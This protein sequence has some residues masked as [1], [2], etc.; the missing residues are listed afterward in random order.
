LHLDQIEDDVWTIPAENM[1]A[2][3]GKEVVFRVPLSKEALS[4]IESARAHERGGFLSPSV[5][6]DVISD[7]TMS[8]YMQRA[9]YEARAHGFR[10]SFRDWAVEVTDAPREVAEM[11]LSHAAGS[12]VERSYLRTD[13]LARRR[14]LMQQW[15]NQVTDGC[16]NVIK[17]SDKRSAQK[18]ENFR[19]T[20]FGTTSW[21]DKNQSRA[22]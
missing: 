8:R 2:R 12:Q 19:K 10:S 5:R 13:H 11:A 4:V 22:L 20:A 9:G 18:N 16:A 15:A 21:R 7:A 14:I 3:K 6:K 17:L 1:K